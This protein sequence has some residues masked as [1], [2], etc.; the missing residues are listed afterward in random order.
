M[1]KVKKTVLLKKSNHTFYVVFKKFIRI[2]ETPS[3]PITLATNTHRVYL[4]L[5]SFNYTRFWMHSQNIDEKQ[6]F[7]GKLY[8]YIILYYLYSYVSIWIL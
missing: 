6:L 7:L 3:T 8:F 5:R 1:N 2:T 4:K